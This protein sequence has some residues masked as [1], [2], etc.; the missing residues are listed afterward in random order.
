MNRSSKPS[1]QQASPN[2][3]QST[4]KERSL[5]NAASFLKDINETISIKSTKSPQQQSPLRQVVTPEDMSS[6]FIPD[7]R[8]KTGSTSSSGKSTTR[9]YDE[10][11]THESSDEDSSLGDP[12][13][14]FSI[15]EPTQTLMDPPSFY[16]ARPH[17]DEIT[18]HTP[19]QT[20]S[21]D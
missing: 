18:V 14:D 1:S 10:K 20:D 7:S 6:P 8:P 4:I 9:S 15:A 2:A 17:P 19:P 5:T 16:S 13:E 21:A 12:N 3:R 11:S